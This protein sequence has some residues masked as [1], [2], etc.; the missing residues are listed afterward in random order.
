[1]YYLFALLDF[2]PNNI[3]DPFAP[4]RTLVW[5]VIIGLILFAA[6]AVPI[7]LF[8][9]RRTAPT[10]TASATPKA[11]PTDERATPI[12][13]AAPY[14]L[15]KGEYAF[16]LQ[17]DTAVAQLDRYVI[18]PKVRIADFLRIRRNVKN[19]Q[20]ARNGILQKHVDF[21]ICTNRPLKP[22]LVIELDDRSHNRPDR[23]R[24]DEFVDAACSDADLP[25]IH[26]RAAATYDS[27]SLK[28]KIVAAIG[29]R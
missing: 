14:L 7:I 26:V 28:R 10:S 29:Q 22:I 6:V 4:I 13:E 16:F 9:F 12:Y 1:M 23:K 20:S 2:D 27:L 15:S 21:L 18:C 25:I 17:L 8:Y 24:R 11:L 19:K 3:P 5:N